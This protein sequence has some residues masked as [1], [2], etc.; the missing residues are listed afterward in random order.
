M[1]VPIG[2][3]RIKFSVGESRLVYGK[4]WTDIIRKQKPLLG[5]L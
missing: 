3:Y 1:F 4:I 5:V 2:Y